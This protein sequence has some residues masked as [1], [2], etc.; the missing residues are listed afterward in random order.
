MS[1]SGAQGSI[2][3][4]SAMGLRNQKVTLSKHRL[5]GTSDICTGETLSLSL[6]TFI[7]FFP[8]QIYL[9]EFENFQG[10]RMD[11]FGECRNLTEKG[12]EKIGSIK[13]ENGP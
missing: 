4:H 6:F 1:H 5:F 13:V 9:F 12:F 7:L 3:S 10:R 8:S 11:L 2:G